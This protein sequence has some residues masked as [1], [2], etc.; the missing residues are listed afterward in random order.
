[1]L[2]VL[3]FLVLYEHPGSQVPPMTSVQGP[4]CQVPRFKSWVSGL[5]FR[6]PG[7]GARV[8]PLRWILSIGSRVLPKVPELWSLFPDIPKFCKLAK[9]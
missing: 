3:V 2:W 4:V 8:L 6:V 5:T 9:F 1:M 7:L